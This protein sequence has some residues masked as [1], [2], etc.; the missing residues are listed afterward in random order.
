MI[1]ATAFLTALEML[2][3]LVIDIMN[4]YVFDLC[5]WLYVIA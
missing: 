2:I 1:V 4:L 5:V 3:V